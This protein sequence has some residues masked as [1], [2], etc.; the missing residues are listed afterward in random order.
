M[1]HT[2]GRTHGARSLVVIAVVALFG[3]V[4]LPGSIHEARAD[5]PVRHRAIR[6]FVPTHRI[7]RHGW[8]T[9]G[10]PTHGRPVH[11]WPTHSRPARRRH[12]DRK[13]TRLNSSHVD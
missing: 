9:H 8:P 12:V 3:G 10:W 7:A 11:R 1:I 13:S 4:Q 6:H 2:S 5:G